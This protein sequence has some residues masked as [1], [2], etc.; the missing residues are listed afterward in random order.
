MGK[1]T[2]KWLA[3]YFKEKILKKLG[4]PLV[5]VCMSA[6]L[7]LAGGLAVRNVV[8]ALILVL[9]QLERA[10]SEMLVFI[11][12]RLIRRQ[13]PRVV[14]AGIW[15]ESAVFIPEMLDKQVVI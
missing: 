5:L 12:D 7:G 10:V 1:C 9:I 8:E 15:W 11:S 3:N 13:A 4:V 2:R 14:D 6:G